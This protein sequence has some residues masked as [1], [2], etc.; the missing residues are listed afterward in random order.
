M[1]LRD[2]MEAALRSAF[3]PSF[4]TV[5]D[6]SCP[7]HGHREAGRGGE[8][9]FAVVIEATAFAGKT[10]LERHRLVYAAIE[11]AFARGAHAVRIT[12]RPPGGG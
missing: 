1:T 2:E 9:H 5:E 3:Q 8:S 10:R 11:P 12:A 7:H 4:L 6:E